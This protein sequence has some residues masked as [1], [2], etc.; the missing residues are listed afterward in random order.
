M[1][2]Y[3]NLYCSP[4]GNWSLVSDGT[5][6]TEVSFVGDALL[7]NADDELPIFDETKRWLEIYF[8]RK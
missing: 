5:Y 1:K 6:L 7:T 2:V 4:I 3:T 8:S